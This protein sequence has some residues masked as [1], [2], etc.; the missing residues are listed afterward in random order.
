MTGLSCDTVWQ[1]LTSNRCTAPSCS[2]LASTWA[3]E[4]QC[5][6]S[7]QSRCSLK[8]LK[9]FRVKLTHS[10][11]IFVKNFPVKVQLLRCAHS[12]QSELDASS[13]STS[14]SRVGP[15]TWTGA[16]VVL[17]KY[18]NAA[19]SQSP[20]IAATDCVILLMAIR[21]LTVTG[22]NNVRLNSSR[23]NWPMIQFNLQPRSEEKG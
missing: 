4:T 23:S 19:Y 6:A 17:G 15:T 5:R 18:T 2:F 12:I 7:V 21:K 10:H 8:S 3:W 9:L 1:T 22:S 11:L 20:S 16:I 14:T 13:I